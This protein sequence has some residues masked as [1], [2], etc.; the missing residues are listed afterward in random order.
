MSGEPVF[1]Q[2]IK[3]IPYIVRPSAYAL[4]RNE[5]GRLATARTKRGLF[6]PGGGIDAGE[7]P[8][9]AATRETSEECGL[10]VLPGRFVGKALEIVH[11]PRRRACVG[12]DSFFFEAS[13]IGRSIPIERDHF[14]EWVELDRALEM[15]LDRSHQ[16][17]VAQLRD[18]FA[19]E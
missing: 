8:E 6:L 13:V 15:L 5:A 3:G 19:I 16:W 2:R 1:G 10:I 9:Q 7:T 18:G 4:V 11:V 17:A 12:K 14:L